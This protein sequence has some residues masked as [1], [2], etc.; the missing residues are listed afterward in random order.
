MKF[1]IV[2]PA[3]NALQWLQGCVRSVADQ[4]SDS[5]Q[6]L[7][8]IQ[9]GASTDGTVEWLQMWQAE[10]AGMAGYKLTFES[11]SD[12]GL[13]DAINI[14]WK[15]MPA[16]ADVTA[17]LNADEQY[18]PNVFAVVAAEMEKQ[19]DADMLLTAHI[20]LDKDS[21]YICH[22]RPTFPRKVVSRA[23][24][25]IITNTCFHR[26]SAFRKRGIYF[27][28]SFRSLADLVFFRDI[29]FTNPRICRM[30]D[31]FG[32]VYVVTGSNVSWSDITAGERQ[33]ISSELP[34]VLK[35]S[36]PL[37]VKAQGLFGL[38]Y[39][40]FRQAPREYAIYLA[41]NAQRSTFAIKRPTHRWNMRS[42]GES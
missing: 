37:F 34:L 1:Y 39:D 30:P 3:Y 19:P 7:H 29:M 38:V 18:L 15:K 16:D 9:D 14:G 12:K 31:L 35:K 23:I 36:I 40:R 4:V 33:R 20:V 11:A 26:A 13:Y 32:S 2:T 10:H 5:V 42:I 17:H 8:H 27:D 24:T 6:V 28:C 41:D 25:Q 21:R 22:R